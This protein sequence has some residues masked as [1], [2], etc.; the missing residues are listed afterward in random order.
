MQ[1]NDMGIP[2]SIIADIID[3]RADELFE[4]DET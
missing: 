4:P 3:A 2:F 1:A